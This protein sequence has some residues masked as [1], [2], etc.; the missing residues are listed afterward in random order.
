MGSR[1]GWSA[2]CSGFSREPEDSEPGRSPELGGGFAVD[3][4]EAGPRTL[5]LIESNGPP[6]VKEGPSVLL[7][8]VE[9][10]RVNSKDCDVREG[11]GCS[12]EEAVSFML[13]GGIVLDVGEKLDPSG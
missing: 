13:L 3:S 2:L 10:K 7:G 9:E 8:G 1:D 4:W 12:N 5:E 11:P 6:E